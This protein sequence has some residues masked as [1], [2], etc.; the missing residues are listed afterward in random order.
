MSAKNLQT[1]ILVL[2]IIIGFTAIFGL[3]N[4]LEKTHPPLPE[5]FEDRDLALHGAKLKNYSLGFNGLIADWY[6]MQSLQYIGNK[7]AKAPENQA[8]NIENLKSLNPRLL[9]PL[10]D[11]AT[12]LDP[13]FLA[14]YS[15]GAVVLPAIDPQQAI[16]IAEK[17]IENNPEQWRL[18]QHL[19]YIYWRLKDFDKASETYEKGSQIQGA[20]PFMRIMAAQMKTKGGSRE[21]AR[22][23]YQQMFDE[24][25]DTQTKESAAI[26]LLEL[27]SFEERDVI[28]SVL[29]T[30]QEKNSR[31]AA[32]WK[33]VFPLLRTAKTKEGKNLNFEEKSLAPIDP[34][35]ALYLLIQTN[36]RCN[37]TIDEKSSKIPIQ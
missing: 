36:N 23:M 13:H 17:G 8:I 31:C 1:I 22:A 34:S 9:Y 16:K 27:D 37:V 30:F 7:V 11:N 35:G 4:F 33:E 3:S 5:G 20:P 26:R 6:W 25:Q 19:G 29:Q 15:Y 28:K 21:T 2:I 24:A 18:Y 12:S 32:N 10:L 14:A